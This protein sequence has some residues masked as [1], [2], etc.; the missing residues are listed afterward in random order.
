MDSKSFEDSVTKI[1]NQVVKIG[2]E[3][4]EKLNDQAFKDAWS[5]MLADLLV[6]FNLGINS[7]T[8]LLREFG[9]SN[10][11]RYSIMTILRSTTLDFLILSY[12][13]TYYFKA[14]ESKSNEDEKIF[15]NQVFSFIGDQL[16]HQIK[17][18]KLLSD[19]KK[20]TKKQYLAS[21]RNLA[22]RYPEFISIDITADDPFKSLKNKKKPPSSETIFKH[23]YSNKMT[24][25]ESQMYFHYDTFSKVEH[26]GIFSRGLIQDDTIM[27]II[28]HTIKFIILGHYRC[29]KFIDKNFGL[30]DNSILI[31]D[32]GTEFKELIK[33][34]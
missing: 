20:I 14:L 26:Y 33:D 27:P 7:S 30:L 9:N 15:N 32:L 4:I 29:H 12:L 17:Q 16:K 19:H 10:S 22:L 28:L 18:F 34:I 1:L 5:L 8:Y 2:N 11:G 25:D 24:R 3:S 23:L 21:L 13:F 6:R 31:N